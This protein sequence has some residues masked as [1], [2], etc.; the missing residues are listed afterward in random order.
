MDRTDP[1]YWHRYCE[2]WTE[3]DKTSDYAFGGDPIQ[4]G[5]WY[6]SEGYIVKCEDQQNPGHESMWQ[7]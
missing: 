6:Y 2:V 4:V 3:F 5:E 7:D 1:N